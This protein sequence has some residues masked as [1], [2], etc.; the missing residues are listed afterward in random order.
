MSTELIKELREATG[1]SLGEIKKALDESGGDK[2][3]AMVILAEKA[4][5]EAAKKAERELGAGVVGFYVYGGGMAAAMVELSCETDFV[6]KNEEFK[7]LAN[8]IAFQVVAMDPTSINNEDGAGEETALLKQSFIKDP[9]QT[10]EQKIE[11]AIQKFGENTKV[12][13][14]VRYSI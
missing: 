7:A 9:S 13:R 10:I 3:K 6:S 1:L 14:F 12:K 4:K 5:E 11:G 8:D 2:E